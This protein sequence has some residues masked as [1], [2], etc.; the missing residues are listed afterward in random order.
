[1]PRET[2][3]S[4]LADHVVFKDRALESFAAR[5]IPIA[6]LYE[7]YFDGSLDILGD[8]SEL[9]RERRHLIKHVITR[10]HLE[11]AVQG[12][13]AAGARPE[14]EHVQRV[15]D[16]YDQRGSDFF[17]A[18]LGESMA[19]SCGHFASG[20][21]TLERAQ[22]RNAERICAKLGLRRNHTLLD[23][24]CGWGHLLAHAVQR[25]SVLG[26]GVTLSSEQA[27]YA[28][29]QLGQLKLARAASVLDADYRELPPAQYDRIAC[30][31][32][33][34]H[35]GRRNLPD[36]FAR[37][38]RLLRD[39]GCFL[40]QW[41]GLRRG[42]DPE[43][44]MW[45][46][47]IEKFIFPG[48]DAGLCLS[49]MLDVVERAGWEVRSVEN[50]GAHCAQTLQR[51]RR[52]W[53]AARSEVIARHGQRWFRVWQFFL[54]W[55]EL[56]VEQGSAACY[57]VLLRRNTQAPRRASGANASRARAHG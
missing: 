24:G 44:R 45:G 50:K 7:S 20:T 37:V 49:S 35:L 55:T 40:L 3:P 2:A 17:R 34:Q 36:F 1:M 8:L 15:R 57:Q 52:N 27:S 6:T 14:G 11:W 39:D 43:A 48:A 10:Q 12:F 53:E 47:F 9:L 32:V 22:R 54:A 56:V 41:T 5:P 26:T 42:L 18:F 19:Y 23:L 25:H 28:R 38:G 30:V 51:W 29:Q 16:L 46:L 21:D 4:R 31:E 13:G 33:V